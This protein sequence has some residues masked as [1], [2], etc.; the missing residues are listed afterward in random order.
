MTDFG[1]ARAGASD[2]TETGSIMGTAQYLS[3]EQAQGHAVSAA[4]DLYSVGVILLRDADRARAVR[5]R[6]G[7]DDRAQARLRAA[8]RRRARSTRRCRPSSRRSC[9]GRS[10]RTRRDAR[11]TPTPFIARARGGAR[12]RARDRGA[13]PADGV[14][15]AGADAVPAAAARRVAPTRPSPP[16]GDEPPPPYYADG[17]PRRAAPPAAVVGVGARPRSRWRRSCVGVVPADAPAQDG[18]AARRRTGRADGDRDAARRRL[19]DRRSSRDEQQHAG[20]SGARAGPGGRREGEEGSTVTLTV[21]GG[22]GDVRRCRRSTGWASRRHSGAADE[23]RPRVD[24]MSN[25][26]RATPCRRAT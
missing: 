12:A 20:R 25:V 24:R 3:P 7:G 18:G 8:A 10:T 23:R 5:R 6:V 19:R 9:C 17:G 15:R 26:S 13:G 16:Y 2:M 21:S 4:S 11:A 14:V 22:P 1:I